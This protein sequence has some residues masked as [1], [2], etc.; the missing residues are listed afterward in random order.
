MATLNILMPHFNDPDGLSLSLGSIAGQ[1]WLGS[2]QV[3]VYDDGSKPERFELAEHV[4]ETSGLNYRLIRNPLNRGRPFARNALLEAADGKYT[5]WLDCGDEWSPDRLEQQFRHLFRRRLSGAG[6]P[7]WVTSHFHW[8]WANKRSVTRNQQIDGDQIRSLIEGKLGAYL[9]TLLGT[10][11]S[12]RNVGWFDTRLSRLQDLDFFIRFCEKGGRLEL[13][14]EDPLCTYHKSDEGRD[15]KVVLACFQHIQ[16]KHAMHYMR[17]SRQF[18]RNRLGD[19]L[20][21]AARFEYNNNRRASGTLL[22]AR[23]ILASPLRSLEQLYKGQ[24]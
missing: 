2:K 15:G 13:A 24:L 20:R 5:A 14:S 18:R 16:T 4:L 17:F 7:I 12:F 19:M 22:V 9:W 1:T 10:T 21:H 6:K 23:S 3:I 8:Q 11:Q